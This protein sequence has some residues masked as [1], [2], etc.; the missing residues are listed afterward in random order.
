MRLGLVRRLLILLVGGTVLGVSAFALAGPSTAATTATIATTSSTATSTSITSTTTPAVLVPTTVVERG[1]LVIH[2]TG[3][4]NPDVD[5]IPALAAQGHEHAW[6]GLEGLFMADDLTVV[7]LECAPSALGTALPKEFTFRCDPAAL[8]VMGDAGI[9]V[10]NLANNHSM[11][12][13]KEA[14]LDGR[15]NL[16]A[17]GIAPV[18]V[19]ADAARAGSPA[20]FYINGWTV[21]VLGFGGVV[22]THDWIATD[23]TAGMRDGDT[24]ETMVEA[25]TGAAEAADLVVV[26][27]HWGVELD[28]EPRTEDRRRAE[29]MIAAGADMIFGHHSHRLQP[30]EMLDGAPVAWGLGNLVWPRMSEAGAD[31]AVARVV[32][33]PDGSLE[34][35]LLPASIAE[36]GHPVIVGDPF[37]GDPALGS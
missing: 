20:L 4:V 12:Y 16:L 32:V 37:C 5:Y 9:E 30:L 22:P 34:A 29:A 31:T 35:C 18:G 14:M 24:I 6:S 28:T 1:S 36:H 15:A 11:D 7:N 2:A 19:G 3:D 25:V 17:A 33:S 26:T 23:E 21:A 27:I 13:G 8:P 10:A